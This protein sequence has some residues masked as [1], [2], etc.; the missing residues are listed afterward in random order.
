LLWL[1]FPAGFETT[2]WHL[3]WAE[4]ALSVMHNGLRLGAVDSVN[5]LGLYLDYQ[6]KWQQHTEK[7]LKKLNMACFMLRK[8]HSL[9]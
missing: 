4:Y 8:L 1:G 9:C 2:I 5:F 7:L 3:T 6:L